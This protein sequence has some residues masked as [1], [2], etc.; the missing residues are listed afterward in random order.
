MNS[1]KSAEF[2]RRLY[3][4]GFA[5]DFH[6]DSAKL[7]SV[8]DNFSGNLN[9]NQNQLKSP[10]RIAE[11]FSE[12]ISEM[13]KDKQS[14]EFYEFGEFRL[15]E[16]KRRLW[17]DGELVALTPKEFEV[18]LILIKRAGKIVEKN[19][20]LDAVWKEVYVE[21]ATL[22]RNISFLRKKLGAEKFIETL[23]KRGY[24]FL[25]VVTLH[26]GEKARKG[27]EEIESEILLANSNL[28]LQTQANRKINSFASHLFR[29]SSSQ[30]FALG[31]G[32]IA[33]AVIGFVVYQFF[34]K[35]SEPKTI[36]VS[37]VTPF[38]GLAGRETMPAFSPDGKQ[39]V[40][41]WNGGAADN[42]DIYV[43]LVGAGESVRLTENAAD[44]IYPAFAPD[45]KSV[46]FLRSYSDR[47]EVFI[48]PALGGAERKIASLNSAW[49]SI[50]FS[51]DGKNLAVIDALEG[52]KQFGV[53][54]IEIA[55]GAKQRLT[56]P[57]EFSSDDVPRFS[58]DGESV[59]FVRASGTVE[60]DLFI[61]SA[62]GGEVRQLTFDKTAIRGAAFDGSGKIIFASHRANNQP[63][64]WRVSAS[65]GESELIATGGKNTAHPAISP[66]GKTIAFVE[67]SSDTNIW[68][69]GFGIADSR[70]KTN[71]KSDIQN[72]KP[73][74][75]SSRADHS[76]QFSPDGKQIVFASD[77]TGS[78]EIWTADADGK[79]QRQLTN[80][81]NAAGSPRFSP[82]GKSVSYDAQVGGNGDIFVVSIDGGEP[83]NL[84]N[85]PESR[86]VLPAWSAD[87]RAIYFT[88]NRAGN[89]Q[90]WKISS[91]GG[92]P[93]QT[94]K[95][96]AFESFASPDGTEIYFT[97][98]RGV[99]GLWKIS[100][101]GGAETPVAEL[102]EAGYWRY[103]TV[104]PD[105]IY[106]VAHSSNSPYKIMFF[107]FAD[108]KLKE[109]SVTDQ[110]PIWI[111]AGLAAAPDGKTILYTQRD[112]NTSNIMF[113]DIGK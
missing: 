13:V 16:K 34:L 90:L 82:D 76:P 5:F 22:T 110:P 36:L 57:P 70:Q 20:L 78:Y 60:Q 23:P 3:D 14:N 58:P 30:W 112:Q 26:E 87:G 37:R 9:L 104:T 44:E 80:S 66:D 17:H 91:S 55:T 18:L 98:A 43:K 33:I 85:T 49:T 51:P 99:S 92:A 68:G 105:G 88:S 106:F 31:F 81:P 97:K 79:N 109:I 95:N 63:N 45:G 64:L 47:S 48:V 39:I 38:S 29:F 8:R 111:Y 7:Q 75:A 65:G 28:S 59:A 108:K 21:E 24:R 84:T 1:G 74:I 100:S 19:D 73:L 83:R 67:E 86:D 10:E 42:L 62:A 2:L 101:A 50:S 41:A 25:P 11:F 4:F 93:E 71:P 46:A 40:F 72:P 89:Y 61:V 56:A 12:R 27:E 113:A 94:T 6:L 69:L 15:D 53:F 54:L 77:R 107:G 32:A 52:E 103:W 102:A 35:K 96:G